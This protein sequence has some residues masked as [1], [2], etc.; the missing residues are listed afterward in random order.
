MSVTFQLQWFNDYKYREGERLDK[1]RKRENDE[2]RDEVREKAHVR[3]CNC[4]RR[5]HFTFDIWYFRVLNFPGLHA[6]ALV[7]ES[8]KGNGFQ[9][10]GIVGKK[11][12]S[13]VPFSLSFLFVEQELSSRL[14]LWLR[15]FENKHCHRLCFLYVVIFSHT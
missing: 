12:P 3:N 1:K 8:P 11:I 13:L 10:G 4:H 7:N 6:H 15:L 5:G 2:W 14:R 9:H